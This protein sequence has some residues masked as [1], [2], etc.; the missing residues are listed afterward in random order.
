MKKTIENM[1]NFAPEIDNPIVTMMKGDTS[2]NATRRYL[3]CQVV[4][5]GGYM[6]AG[7]LTQDDRWYE[8]GGL[9]MCSIAKDPQN[10]VLVADQRFLAE[11]VQA[12]VV[13]RPLP[14]QMVQGVRKPLIV[15]GS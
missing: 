12:I 13:G 9:R 2:A 6:M 4:L 1:L 5:K 14:E 3:D 7:I 11:D 15:P 10:K 8:N